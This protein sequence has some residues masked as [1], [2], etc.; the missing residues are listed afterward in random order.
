MHCMLKTYCY[1]HTLR[2][3][4]TYCFS[5]AEI[6]RCI[7]KFPDYFHRPP[8]DGT[9]W[10]HALC[11]RA[12][13]IATQCAKWR[14]CVKIGSCTTRVFVTTCVVTFAI[15]AWTWNWS[16]EQ[17]SNSVSNSANLGWRL[18]KCY[19]VRM[20]MRPCVLRCVSSG[21]RASRDAEHHS[22]T[23]RGQGDLPRAQPLKMW[24]IWWLVHEDRRRTIKEIAAVFFAVWGR[25]FGEKDLNCG[26][27]AIGCSMMTT[28]P[29]TELS[30]HVSFSPTTTLPH[31]RIHLTLQIWPL[32]T[33][34]CSRRWS[35][36]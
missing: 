34:S 9:T 11:L 5:G 4:N 2:I 20:E 12:G 3:C 31:F 23:T 33:S 6:R 7:K 18:L 22:K 25:T 28:H 32:A 1:Q 16:S 24:T 30:Q 14:R 26:A 13:N 29:L 8:T 36:C 35:C 15:S 17:T 21:T 27:R 10:M 19:D